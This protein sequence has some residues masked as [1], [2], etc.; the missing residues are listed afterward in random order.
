MAQRFWAVQGPNFCQV[1]TATQAGST[2]DNS[3]RVVMDEK[4][5]RKTCLVDSMYLCDVLTYTIVLRYRVGSQSINSTS[6]LCW[7]RDELESYERCSHVANKVMN[8]QSDCYLK[9]LC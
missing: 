9:V 2:K 6:G 5:H 7:Q 4:G 8:N 1:L 3:H